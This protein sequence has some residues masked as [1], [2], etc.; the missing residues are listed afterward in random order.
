MEDAALIEK[1]LLFGLGRQEAAIYLCLLKQEELTGYEA[2]KLTGISRSNVY[3]GLASLVEHGAAYILEGTST[4]YTAVGLSEICENRLRY[5]QR[6]KEELEKNGPQKQLPKEGYITIE[7]NGHIRDKIHHMILSA[8]FR[9]YFSASGVFLEE[10]KDEI[11]VLVQQGKKVV[12][13]SEDGRIPFAEEQEMLEGIQLYLVPEGLY[14]SGEE[15]R[16]AQ[17]RLIIDSEYVL[18]GEIGG[19]AQDACLYSAQK[20]FVRVFKDAMRNEIELIRLREI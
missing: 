14:E 7:G 13:I 9:I 6:T 1:L 8:E 3:N 19:K 5:L 12:L 18:T 10:W 11:G 17:I 2:A 16:S 4:R 15:D 20:N